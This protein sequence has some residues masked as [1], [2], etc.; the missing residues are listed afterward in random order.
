ML[1]IAHIGVGK[2]LEYIVAGLVIGVLARL[3]MPG[4]Q[5]MGV[6]ATIALGVVAAIGG[7][8]LW[9][10]VF[11]DNDGIAWIGAL[12]VALVLLWIYRAI[13]PRMG[14]TKA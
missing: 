6:I 3:I 5:H 13:A 10:A 14:K 7:G 12:I 2:I 4:K 1:A 9:N 11:P 8:I